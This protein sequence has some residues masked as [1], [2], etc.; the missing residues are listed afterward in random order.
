MLNDEDRK[1]VHIGDGAY[2]ANEG[3]GVRL[4][5]SNGI[6]VMNE[7][8]IDKGDISRLRRTLDEFGFK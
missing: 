2:I 8:F 4:F 5:T 3:F 7:V 1:A 6:H